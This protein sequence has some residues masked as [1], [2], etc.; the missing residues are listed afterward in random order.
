MEKHGTKANILTKRNKVYKIKDQNKDTHSSRMESH[1]SCYWLIVIRMIPGW[2][3]DQV[4]LFA[5]L[6]NMIMEDHKSH[7]HPQKILCCNF[8][9]LVQ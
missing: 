4:I 5:Q 3:S 1:Y 9:L 6:S 2:I 7:T 8:E